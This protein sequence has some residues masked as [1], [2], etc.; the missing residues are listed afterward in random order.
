MGKRFTKYL[1]Y[2]KQCLITFIYDD[3]HRCV[4]CG[5]EIDNKNLCLPCMKKLKRNN[6]NPI[7]YKNKFYIFSALYYTSEAKELLLNFKYKKNFQCGEVIAS[8]MIECIKENNIEFD[9]IIPAPIKADSYKTR[10]FNQSLMLAKTIGAHFDRKVL[11]VLFFNKNIRNQKT[12]NKYDREK[13][14]KGSISIKS[15]NINLENSRILIID[16]VITTGS[17]LNECVSIVKGD[18]N[19]LIKVLTGMKSSI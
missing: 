11:D 16:D 5:N 17:T 15:T 14:I 4:L 13:N 18:K 6:E 8:L 7:W 10:G 2:I 1:S 3:E 9:Y 12:L 19:I